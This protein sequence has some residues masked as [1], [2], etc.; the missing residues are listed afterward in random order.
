MEYLKVFL[1]YP[2]YDYDKG[3]VNLLKSILPFFIILHHLTNYPGLE[4]LK[5]IGVP[6]MGI[7]FAMSGYGVVV[8]Y[9]KN[10]NYIKGFLYRDL[11]KLFIPYFIALFLFIVYRHFE[12]IDQISLLKN[13]GGAYFISNLFSFVPTSWFI[14]VLALHYVFFFIVFRYVKLNVAFKILVVFCLVM[15]YYF[16]APYINLHYGRYSACPGFC[17]GMLFAAYDNIIKKKLVRWHVIA[18][19]AFLLILI[20]L[21]FGHRLDFFYYPS[22]VFLTMYVLRPYGMITNSWLVR[23][24]SS[25]SLEMFLIQYLPIW[26]VT[27]HIICE[28]TRFSSTLIVVALVFLMDV[29]LAFIVHQ[30]V[31]II[32]SIL[33]GQRSKKCLVV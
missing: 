32:K 21:P 11:P 19:L 13:G 18:C 1:L 27:S 25:I 4:I 31:K 33:F 3:K 26:F 5:W 7:F 14:F 6:V 28:N 10:E 17:V 24:L 9:L 12:G 23:F 20:E 22:V 2:L 8:S 29:L 30:L 15:V 16:I